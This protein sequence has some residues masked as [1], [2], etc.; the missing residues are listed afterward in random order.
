MSDNIDLEAI[1][2]PIPGDN[3][4]GENLRY[5]PLYE[6]IREA[7]RADDPL[8]QGD[9]QR[10]IKRADWDKVI[11][12]SLQCLASRSKDLQIAAWLTEGLIKKEGFQG[13]VLGFQI[14]NSFMEQYWDSCYPEIEEGD[15]EYRAAPMEFMNEKLWVCVR[16]VPLT[17]E[18]RTNG[19]SW[20]KWK[21]SREVGYEN[22]LRNRYGDID[23]SK[24]SLR[25]ERIGEGKLTA[26]DFDAAVALSSKEYY[27]ALARQITTA[28]QEF[29]T[30]DGL[31]DQKFGKAAPR[32]AEL[33]G[34]I[35]DCD[36]LVTKILKD[37][38]GRQP[39]LPA[40][41][42]KEKSGGVL[43]RLFKRQ[44]EV[45]S[46]HGESP[47]QVLP[48]RRKGPIMDETGTPS[49]IENTAPYPYPLNLQQISDT[50]NLEKAVW[51]EVIQ[52]FEGSGMKEAL[53]KLLAAS[54][55]APSVREK[56]RYR[57]LMAKLCLRAERP[58]LA[59]PVIEELYSL[60]EELH[61]ER[62]ESPLWI[63]E[64]LDTLYQCLSAGEPS[65]DELTRAKVLFQ[66]LCTTDVTK[67]MMYRS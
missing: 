46:E 67:A 63:A 64:V 4:A 19:Y 28:Y 17:D 65:D 58:D 45:P 2:A 32:L 49:A 62:W 41:P 56:N 30:L 44:R 40:E 48:I 54:F 9:W 33:K 6:E 18:S 36:Q 29:S 38:G 21:E 59:K 39:T 5:E 15:L 11:D 66:R 8:A 53:D 3:P 52:T 14:L 42:A 51:E 34:A 24:K 26:E 20:L 13:L 50:G 12:L 7:R 25:D 60:I 61:L 37:K 23:E 10:D 1:L 43:S 55:S 22:D 31:V 16:E 27:E 47:S 57:L 35:E